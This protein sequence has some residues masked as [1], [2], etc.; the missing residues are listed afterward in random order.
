MEM[1]ETTHRFIFETEP[2]VSQLYIQREEYAEFSRRQVNHADLAKMLGLR[3]PRGGVCTMF[4]NQEIITSLVRG[5]SNVI[6]ATEEEMNK[7][8][9]IGIQTV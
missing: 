2:E 7:A 1:R 3:K 9:A 6:A 4:F 8:R 5:S